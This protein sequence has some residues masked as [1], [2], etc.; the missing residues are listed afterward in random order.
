MKNFRILRREI[1]FT[2]WV[3]NGGG[4]VA[5]QSEDGTATKSL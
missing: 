3:S 5:L 4:H 1:E 2:L